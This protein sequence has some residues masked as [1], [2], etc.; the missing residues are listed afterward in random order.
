MKK[1]LI[2]LL[3]AILASFMVT[4]NGTDIHASSGVV[5]IEDEIEDMDLLFEM[6]K[7]IYDEADN[8]LAIKIK[9]KKDGKEVKNEFKLKKY[10]ITQKLKVVKH[11]NGD[12]IT[13]YTKT[14]FI[15]DEGITTFIL[16]DDYF[17]P[18]PPPPFEY[19]ASNYRSKWDATGDLKG[20][21]TIYWDE[22]ISPTMG[23]TVDL[24]RVEGGATIINPYLEVTS[25]EVMMLQIGTGLNGAQDDRMNPTNASN[26]FLYDAPVWWE[27]LDTSYSY[28]VGA[29]VTINIE[30]NGATWQI[31]FSNYAGY[32]N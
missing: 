15:I 3:T 27:P 5:F 30:R 16:D 9:I 10:S 28:I 2:I 17:P 22:A 13:T 24:L 23:M 14:E 20:Y 25:T 1:Y 18:P 29:Y 26:P 6:A 31:V 4:S 11:D 32:N 12:V 19:D 7:S 21:S 8:S